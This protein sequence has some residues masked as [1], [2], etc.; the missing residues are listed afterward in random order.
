MKNIEDMTAVELGQLV[1]LREISPTEVLKYFKNR[2]EE[3]NPEL[4]AFTYTK[5]EDAFNEAKK[6]E[7]KLANNEY[8]GPFAGVPICLKDFLPSKKGWHNSHG[9]SD[10]GCQSCSHR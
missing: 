3:R 10:C 7:N 2:I 8:V 9:D 5:F 4:N 6:I 1:N